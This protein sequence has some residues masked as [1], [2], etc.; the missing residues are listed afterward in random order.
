MPFAGRVLPARRRCGVK[1][2]IFMFQGRIS[3]LIILGPGLVNERCLPVTTRQ[4]TVRFVVR[5]HLLEVVNY[6]SL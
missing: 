5:L 3:T 2:S 1:S 6:G 4:Q